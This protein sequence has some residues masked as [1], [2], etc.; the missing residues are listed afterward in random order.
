MATELTEDELVELMQIARR[1]EAT[2]GGTFQQVV[3]F[4]RALLEAARWMVAHAYCDN[5]DGP[6]DE[7]ECYVGRMV[8]A[9]RRAG[10]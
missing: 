9:A 4:D 6:L 1:Y 5:K 2:H 7:H 10:L 3:N 8:R